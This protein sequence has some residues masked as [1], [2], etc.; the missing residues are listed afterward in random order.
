MAVCSSKS[1]LDV[2]W[3]TQKFDGIMEENDI[4]WF[5]LYSDAIV[6]VG[7]ISYIV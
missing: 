7:V 6:D 4:G 2:G 1:V 5:E 3:L